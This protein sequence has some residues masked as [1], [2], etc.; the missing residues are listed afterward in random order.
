MVAFAW[1]LLYLVLAFVAYWGLRAIYWWVVEYEE[2]LGR[3][4]AEQEEGKEDDR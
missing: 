3:Q 4:K 2:R 1:F